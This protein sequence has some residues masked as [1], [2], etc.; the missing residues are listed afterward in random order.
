ML[1]REVEINDQSKNVGLK[2]TLS[3]LRENR[4]DAFFSPLPASGMNLRE[5]EGNETTIEREN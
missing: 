1:F 2:V 3:S 4:G 5:C